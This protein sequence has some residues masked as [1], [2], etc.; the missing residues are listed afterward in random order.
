MILFTLYIPKFVIIIHIHF[1]KI[2]LWSLSKGIIF[3]IIFLCDKSNAI[4]TWLG[5]K[6]LVN[7]I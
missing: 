1:I 4:I 6:I 5:I 3:I 7:K 2:R